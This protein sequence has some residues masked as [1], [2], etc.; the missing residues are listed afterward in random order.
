MQ[1]CCFRI[2][3]AFFD[4]KKLQVR[5]TIVFAARYNQHFFTL[6]RKE[7]NAFARFSTFDLYTLYTQ[8]ICQINTYL[9]RKSQKAAV[10]EPCIPAVADAI[11]QIRL[12]RFTGVV[13]CNLLCPCA[14]VFY[15]YIC[16]QAC[17][18]VDP[19]PMG[20]L[21]ECSV[22]RTLGLH[23]RLF[24]VRFH[25]RLL[26]QLSVQLWWLAAAAIVGK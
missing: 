1:F 16:G 25:F 13:L 8:N 19:C 24:R 21:A 22:V 14:P 11:A 7:H 10:R 5:S 9:L 2:S 23:G 17:M 4:V 26:L 6:M 20:S 18:Y 15:I 12:F 3:Q